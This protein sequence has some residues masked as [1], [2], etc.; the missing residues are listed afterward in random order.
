MTA[1]SSATDRLRDALSHLPVAAYIGDADVIE[2]LDQ[3]MCDLVVELRDKGMSPE[4]VLLTVKGVAFEAGLG[5]TSASLLERIIT[6]C[7]EQYFK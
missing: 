7:I 5:L 2:P 6:R 4:Q 1:P 3:L